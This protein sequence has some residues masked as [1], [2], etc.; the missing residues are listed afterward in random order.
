MNSKQKLSK[1]FND[2]VINKAEFTYNKTDSFGKL[3]VEFNSGVKYHYNNVD[4]VSA[5]ALFGHTEQYAFTAHNKYIESK[6]RRSKTIYTKKW[7]DKMAEERK[8]Q[9]LA[10]NN[11]AR[12]ARKIKAKQ[13]KQKEEANA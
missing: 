5:E 1:K 13:L 7:K 3:V 10:K 6:Y 12:R 2:V 4:F 11:A 9:Y 8:K